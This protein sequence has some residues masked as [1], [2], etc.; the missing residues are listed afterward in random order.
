MA[1]KH[2]LRIAVAGGGSWGTA[3]AHML[4]CGGHEP[5][6]WMRDAAVVEAVNATG[7]NPRYLPGRTLHAGLRATSDMAVFAE[8]DLVLLAVPCQRMREF[9]GRAREYFTPGLILVNASKG[10]ELDSLLRMSSLVREMLHPLDHRYVMLSGPSFAAEVLDGQP[11]AVVLACEEQELGVRLRQAFSTPVFRCYSS[12]DLCGVELGG[13]VKNVM[14]IAAGLCDGLGLGHN[15]R[16]ALITRGLAEI[17]R[18]GEA[19][20]AR[21]GTFMGLSGLGDLVLSCT[22]D[23]SRNRR[24]GLALARGEE[25]DEIVRT[26]GSV[27][28][29]V[30]TTFAVHRLGLAHGVETPITNAVHSI[31]QGS[32][33][34]W[35][36]IQKLML[37]TLREE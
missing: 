17:S 8:R 26:L 31:L 33:T 10:I 34:P 19:L 7:E 30:K 21:P 5:L 16:A 22:G 12:T 1:G 3:L 14:A 35:Q 27:A 2:R 4:A 20:G 13:A 9:L 6:L 18:L 32:Q 29:G 36:A 28:E 25:L 37:R 15:S 11:T 24:V 23:L